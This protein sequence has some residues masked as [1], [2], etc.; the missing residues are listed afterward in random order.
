V[1]AKERLKVTINA[2][3][4]GVDLGVFLMA[5]SD[6]RKVEDIAEATEEVG[7][8]L[9]MIATRERNEGAFVLFMEARVCVSFLAACEMIGVEDTVR[10]MG[11]VKD[12]LWTNVPSHVDD[13]VCA[14]HT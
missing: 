4:M 2:R 9:L 12:V 8:V 3:V 10:P 14:R 1:V 7:D 5:A 11:E 13:V 6:R